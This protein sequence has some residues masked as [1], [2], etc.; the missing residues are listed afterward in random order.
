MF[1]N[2]NYFEHYQVFIWYLSGR[3]GY[4]IVFILSILSVIYKNQKKLILDF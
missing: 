2:V 4:P 1:Y 3:L